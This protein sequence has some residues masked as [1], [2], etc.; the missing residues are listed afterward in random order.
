MRWIGAM[1]VSLGLATA[2]IADVYQVEQL[3]DNSM[4][5][6]DL[7]A[8]VGLVETEI[9][10]ADEVQ[11]QAKRA[12]DAER[13]SRYGRKKSPLGELLSTTADILEGVKNMSGDPNATAQERY[14]AARERERVATYRRSHFDPSTPREGLLGSCLTRRLLNNLFDRAICYH[15]VQQIAVA[16]S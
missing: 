14:N 7:V 6:A 15:V 16:V 11:T 13:Q 10:E 4:S 3:E 5:C 2:A 8:E 9:N 1:F 12:M